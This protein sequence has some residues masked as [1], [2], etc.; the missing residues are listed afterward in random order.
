MK[1]IR[2]IIRP[3]REEAVLKN[4]ESVSLYAIS[5][6]PVLGR[7]K[8]RGVQVGPVRYDA[9][10]KLILL[11]VVEENDYSKAIEA[12]ERGADTGHPGD[13]KV[14][15]QEVSEVYTIRT[16]ARTKEGTVS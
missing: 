4:L 10:A 7:G 3:E 13:G 14:F 8:Q 16:G 11:L 2:A 15:V 12:I 6:T 1:M 5:K 9:L